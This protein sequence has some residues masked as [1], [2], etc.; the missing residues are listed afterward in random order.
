MNLRTKQ[1]VLL[2]LML[3]SASLGAALKPTIFLSDELPAVDL[4]TMV[5]TAFGEWRELPGTLTQIVNPQQQETL[6]KIYSETLSRSYVN[7]Q[8]YRVMLSIAYGKNQNKSLE[9]HSPE[10]CY[11]A[12]GFTVADRRKTSLAV[13]GKNIAATQID[14]HLGQRFEPV[15]FW[16]VIGSTVPATTVQKRLVEFRY[17]VTGRIPDGF[18]VRVSSIDKETAQA[19]A[20]QSRFADDLMRALAPQSQPRFVGDLATP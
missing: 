15:T 19:Y 16:T 1:W 10:V 7:A 13:L 3:V 6:E 11:P 14:T 12:Q 5:P 9:L 20:L 4:Q 17:A 18:L 2:A 8:G